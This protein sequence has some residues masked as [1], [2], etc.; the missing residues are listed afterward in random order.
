LQ[1]LVVLNFLIMRTQSKKGKQTEEITTKEKKIV[2]T[3]QNAIAKI[4]EQFEPA[5]KEEATFFWTTLKFSEA[6][7]QITSINYANETIITHLELGG[8]KNE[9]IQSVGLIWWLKEV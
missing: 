3:L 1:R 4:S 6:I 7:E 8:Y 5:T 2:N 9:Y